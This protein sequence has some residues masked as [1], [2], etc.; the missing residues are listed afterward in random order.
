MHCIGHDSLQLP[1]ELPC[2]C[3]WLL[4]CCCS[5]DSTTIEV[6][7]GGLLLVLKCR[8]IELE[9]FVVWI[10]NSPFLQPI[11]CNSVKEFRNIVPASSWNWWVHKCRCTQRAQCIWLRFNR[12]LG[13]MIDWG[14]RGHWHRSLYRQ[15]IHLLL[16]FINTNRSILPLTRINHLLLLLSEALQSIL[17]EKCMWILRLS[18]RIVPDWVTV[19]LDDGILHST[20]PLRWVAVATD[21]GILHS[22]SNSLSRLDWDGRNRAIPLTVNYCHFRCDKFLANDSFAGDVDAHQDPVALNS[23][24][25]PM[26]RRNEN[27][28]RK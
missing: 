22:T 11:N 24:I 21:D 18:R 7:A 9:A 10:N 13:T 25:F 27:E 20:V 15:F 5:G 4:L 8:W 19:A 3:C 23:N 12:W 6:L 26:I 16:L 17:G 1:S 14:C 2:C 28:K